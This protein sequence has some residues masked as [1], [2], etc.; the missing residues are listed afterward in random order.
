[1]KRKTKALAAVPSG[2]GVTAGR[3]NRE[4]HES[5]VTDTLRRYT[6]RGGIFGPQPLPSGARHPGRG[7]CARSTAR[8]IIAA[9][10]EIAQARTHLVAIGPKDGKR[11]RKLWGQLGK[12][13]KRL[14]AANKYLAACA[15]ED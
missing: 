8:E 5:A 12:L 3:W 9:N 1:M 6:G 4:A 2:R 14:D 15:G 13:E 7:Q 11:T 10:R